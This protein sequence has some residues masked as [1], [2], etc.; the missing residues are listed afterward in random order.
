MVVCAV[1]AADRLVSGH[2]SSLACSW[3]A[4]AWFPG[5]PAVFLS[6]A[7]P[8]VLRSAVWVWAWAGHRGPKPG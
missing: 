2:R 1:E 5:G 8:E 3:L 6:D 7:E 4:Y